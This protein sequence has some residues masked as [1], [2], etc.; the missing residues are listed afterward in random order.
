[1]EWYIIRT[2]WK[3][4]EA[5]YSLSVAATVI[6]YSL[7]LYTVYTATIRT[8]YVMPNLLLPM[9]ADDLATM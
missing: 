5:A 7:W 3:C 9:I 6:A 8:L 2:L 1:M 4:G